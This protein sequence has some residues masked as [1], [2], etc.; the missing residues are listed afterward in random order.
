VVAH[1]Y[2]ASHGA[3]I[4]V[5]YAIRAVVLISWAGTVWLLFGGLLSVARYLREQ[6]I[7]LP[8]NVALVLLTF[9]FFLSLPL[10]Q[11]RLNL[12]ALRNR[13]ASVTS[14]AVPDA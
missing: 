5:L 1:M 2:A 7:Q 11:R 9:V 6:R 10:L 8:G 4:F 12:S 14:D 3:S 13:E